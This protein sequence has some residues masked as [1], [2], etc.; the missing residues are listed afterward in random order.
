MTGQNGLYFIFSI[1]G[2]GEGI[3][4]SIFNQF[5]YKTLILWVS[6]I[7]ILQLFVKLCQ[8]EF[9][10]SLILLLCENTLVMYLILKSL[11]NI[12]PLPDKQ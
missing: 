9:S 5:M 2:L 7:D 1:T 8:L 3:T 4:C 11:S 6:F 12:L 10:S